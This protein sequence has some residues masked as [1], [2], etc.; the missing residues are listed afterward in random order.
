MGSKLDIL[1]MIE[2]G[3]ISVEQGLE[4]IEALEQTEHIENDVSQE[5]YSGQ[6]LSKRFDIAL[7]SCKLNVE[8][9][10]VED[11]TLEIRDDK[12]RE[13]VDM[14]EW[15]EVVED[16]DG[17][18]IKEKRVGGIQDFF[19]LFKGDKRHD[20]VLYINLKL[21][22]ETIIDHGRFTSVSG[23]V[24]LIGLQGIN[25]EAKSVS[26]KVY[27]ADIKVKT[28]QLKSISGQVVADNV[29]AGKASMSST[30]GKVKVTGSQKHCKCSTVSGSVTYIGTHDME[31][32]NVSTVSG[33]VDVSLPS[34]EDYNL[35][36]DSVSGNIDASGF[37]VPEKNKAGKKS[38]HVS[39][40]SDLKSIKIST[41]SGR[42]TY[43]KCS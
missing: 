43:D 7:T 28:L 17:I 30:S 10:N 6:M 15:L 26:G 29:K 14:P 25:I 18:R 2:S 3:E 34:P 12:S 35:A 42:I 41:V 21:P 1:K 37:A 8:R 5:R 40:R 39:N 4:L 16:E 38:I 33:S 27:G 22:M 11:V 9:S 32:L 23:T 19:D 20:Q 24:S 13:L 31:T 36:F